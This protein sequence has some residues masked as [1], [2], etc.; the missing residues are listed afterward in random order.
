MAADRFDSLRWTRA[1]LTRVR[2]ALGFSARTAPAARRWQRRLRARITARLGV[3]LRSVPLRGPRIVSRRAFPDYVREGWVYSAAP[4]LDAFAWWLVPRGVRA[5]GSCVVCV[6]G[7]GRGVDP[8]VGIGPDGRPRRF[9]A[10]GEYQND[11]ALQCIAHGHA[12]LAI[13]P[14]GFGRRRDP[15][16]R[17]KGPETSSCQP[18]AGAALLLGE[19]MLGWRVRDAMA[20][21]SLLR[22]RPDVDPRRIGIM[23][24]S[25]GGTVSLFTAAL[26]PRIA[27]AVVSG[28]VNTFT[29]S[30]GSLSHCLD[31]YVPGLLRDCDMSD[32]AG[33]IAPRPLFV[34]SGTRDPIFPVAATRRAIRSIRTAYRALRAPA[35]LGCE[36]FRGD[37][38]FHGRG[39]FRFLASRL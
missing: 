13:E 33:L 35:Q 37:H 36:I 11:F 34:E 1:R 4:G 27:A 25:G 26:D 30:V 21:V 39:A 24:I 22:A 6:P 20:A 18:A 16:A 29:D 3:E 9:G 38:R 5:A 8:I 31:N 2:P 23:G 17:A 15:A 14:L 19:T 28:Y 10:W 12:V 32:V 7:H